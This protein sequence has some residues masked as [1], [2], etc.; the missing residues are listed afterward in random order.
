MV[1]ASS[2]FGGGWLQRRGDR[3][4]LGVHVQQQLIIIGSSHFLLLRFS[5][6]HEETFMRIILVWVLYESFILW[7]NRCTSLNMLFNLLLII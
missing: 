3:L 1:K 5:L 2:N 7:F 4:L 6:V